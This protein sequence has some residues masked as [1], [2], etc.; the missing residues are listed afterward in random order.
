[1]EAEAVTR[2][3]TE[4]KADVRMEQRLEQCGHKPAMGGG[5]APEMAGARSRVSPRTLGEGT[6]PD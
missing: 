3:H 4:G 6:L 1:M 2:I 5:S